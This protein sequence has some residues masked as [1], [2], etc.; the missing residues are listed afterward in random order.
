MMAGGMSDGGDSCGGWFG[1]YLV[2]DCVEDA[3]FD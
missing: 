2:F 1:E 3:H